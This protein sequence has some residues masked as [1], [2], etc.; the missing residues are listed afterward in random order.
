MPSD[1]FRRVLDAGRALQAQLP[2]LEM[3]AVNGVAAALHAGHRET[4]DIDYCAAALRAE[5]E[6]TVRTLQ[7][8]P[9]WAPQRQ[10]FAKMILGRLGP[11][12]VGLRQLRRA[13]PLESTTVDGLVVTSPAE[14]LRVKA[15]QALQRRATRD[16]IDVV[17]LCD[18]IGDRA[19]VAT[20]AALDDFY[21]D[22]TLTV[23]TDTPADPPVARPLAHALETLPTHRPVDWG[24]AA[25]TLPG[26]AGPYQALGYL[27]TRL[28]TLGRLLADHRVAPAP[29]RPTATRPAPH[30][31]P[32]DR[33]CARAAE[34]APGPR[35]AP[36]GAAA[37]RR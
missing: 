19:A 35:R 16:Y 4:R 2:A 13:H 7:A 18:A 17:A 3:I 6:T 36:P 26:V 20:L 30:V 1:A 33:E 9:A 11:V 24:T 21:P 25:G 10:A 22:T 34:T 12:R 23:V 31:G 29:P 15:M 32:S 5:W 14:T 8:W 27:E 28:A 37:D